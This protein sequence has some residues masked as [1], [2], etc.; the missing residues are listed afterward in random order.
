MT[1]GARESS[2]P[3]ASARGGANARGGAHRVR[4]APPRLNF[5]ARCIRRECG[6]ALV[7]C[8]LRGP[9]G[10]WEERS[11]QC[12]AVVSRERPTRRGCS[13][14]SPLCRAVKLARRRRR[15]RRPHSAS[16]QLAVMI[17]SLL[18]ALGAVPLITLNNGVKMPAVAAGTWCAAP[19]HPT[20]TPCLPPAEP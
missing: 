1:R 19:H 6:A 2:Y 8:A 7:W 18:Y 15:P 9:R 10:A 4:C 5:F 16:K 13:S 20:C 3:P 14:R 17:A 11:A 12:C